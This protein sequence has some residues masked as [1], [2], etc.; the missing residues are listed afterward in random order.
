[1]PGPLTP[2]LDCSLVYLEIRDGPSARAYNSSQSHGAF[3]LT[4]EG[5]RPVDAEVGELVV[6]IRKN[7]QQVVRLSY[8][9]TMGY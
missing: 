8:E 5:E 7:S 4:I 1:M 9:K 2:V 6:L 3:T